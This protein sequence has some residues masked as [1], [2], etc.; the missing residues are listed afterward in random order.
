MRRT[1][2]VGMKDMITTSMAQGS[3]VPMKRPVQLTASAAACYSAHAWP[4]ALLQA[5]Q[6]LHGRYP[7]SAQSA[8]AGSCPLQMPAGEVAAQVAAITG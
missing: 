3:R 7:A 6:L 5:V 8:G 2:A 4:R 1:T